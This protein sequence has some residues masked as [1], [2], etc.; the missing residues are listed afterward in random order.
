[1]LFPRAA[2]AAMLL[3]VA[4]LAGCGG[5]GGDEDHPYATTKSPKATVDVSLADY[6]VQP[7]VASVGAGPV[8]FV[9]KN[10]STTQVHELAVLRLKDD[11]SF[12][13]TGELENVEPGASGQ[14]TLDLPAGRYLLACVIVPGEA[15]STVDHFQA[16]MKTAFEVR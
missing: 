12:D 13:N 1:M 2:A 3:G 5:G 6:S 11:G 10:V 8:R 4:L 16:G 7:A 15:G 14:I 9:A